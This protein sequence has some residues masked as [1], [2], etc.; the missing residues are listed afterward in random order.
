MPTKR[1]RVVTGIP[2]LD[3][4]LNGGLLPGRNILVSGP[5]GS[6]KSTFAMHFLQKGVEEKEPSLYVTLEESREKLYADMAEFGID[7]KKM[8]KTKKFF[9]LGGPIAELHNYM[10]K[11]DATSVH[12]VEEIQEVIKENKIKRIVIDSLNHLTMLSPCE[13]ERRESLAALCNALSGLGVT[14]LLLSEIHEGEFRLSQHG[15]EEFVVDGVIVLYHFKQGSKFVPGLSIRKMRGSKHEMDVKP[16]A[17][18][19]DGFR[20]YPNETLF[21]EGIDMFN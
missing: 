11:V 4:M 3:P 10:K 15:I 20:V 21:A 19:D 17:I 1:K 7:L 9:F 18:T 2:G 5:A 14:S 16:Y 13:K 8:E 12:L 6:G